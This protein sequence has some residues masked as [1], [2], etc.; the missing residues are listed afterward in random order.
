MPPLDQG[1]GGAQ[2]IEDGAAIG[3]LLKNLTV[4]P[5]DSTVK[6]DD[7][8]EKR[9]EAFV[10]VRLKRA[11]VMQIFSNAGQDEAEKIREDA[12]RLLG[13]GVHV[14]GEFLSILLSLKIVLG[15]N[16][17]LEVGV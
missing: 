9:L 2:S 7:E 1:Q 11:S 5:D 10:V 16:P 17:D 8:I 13:E 15:S 6:L 12:S 4:T 14:P 3:V